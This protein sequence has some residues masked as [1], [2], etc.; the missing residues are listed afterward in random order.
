MFDTPILFLIYKRPDKTLKVFEEIRKIKPRQLFVVGDGPKS[1]DQQAQCQ[2][3]R[4]VI[5]KVDWDC[6][7]KTLFREK[8]IGSKYSVS[9][10][11]DWFFSYVDEGIILEDDCLPNDSFFFFCAELLERYRTNLKIM[12]ISGSN[13]N[14]NINLDNTTYH[15][16]RYPVTWGWATWKRAWSNYDLELEDSKFYY[17]LIE[18]RFND[19]FERRVWKTVLRTLHQL[20]AWDY[21][22]IF[23]I[24]K[25]NG[26]CANTNH[27]FVVNI[28]FD[29]GAT[30]TTYDNPYADLKTETITS[31]VHPETIERSKEGEEAFLKKGFNL[32]RSGYLKYVLFRGNNLIH[33]IKGLFKF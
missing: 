10:G 11:I 32:E 1:I 6:E 13:L 16:S 23:A 26:L 31:I 14:D 20:D 9:S 29:E 25:A 27:N 4:D 3:A 5:L 30:H 7:V 18:K 28:G 24:L 33:K 22:W 12:H 17:K 19:P 8:N 21:Q 2:L 15:F